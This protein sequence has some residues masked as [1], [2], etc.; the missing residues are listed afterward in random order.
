MAQNPPEGTPQVM[1]YVHY[2]DAQAALEFLTTAFGF[3]ERFRMDGPDGRIAHAEVE[4]G[5]RG[6]VMLG[7][8]GEGYRSPKNLDSQGTSSF[9]VY[10]DDVDEHHARAK[11]AGATIVRE[12]EDQFYGDRNYGVVDLEGHEWYFATHVRDVSSEEMVQATT[13][14]AA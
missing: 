2:E 1:P 10:V 9:Y 14:S 5:D 7:E 8:P 3:R 6:V 13:S 11:A 4:T 12:P